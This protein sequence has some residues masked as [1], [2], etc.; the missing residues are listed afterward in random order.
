VLNNSVFIQTH[1]MDNFSLL[2]CN[3]LWARTQQLQ[4]NSIRLALLAE[5]LYLEDLSYISMPFIPD[6]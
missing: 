4:G 3:S 2:I 6:F 5:T 1:N